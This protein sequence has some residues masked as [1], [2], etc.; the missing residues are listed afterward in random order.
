MN[1]LHESELHK[2]VHNAPVAVTA[3]VRILAVAQDTKVEGFFSRFTKIFDSVY[4][5]HNRLDLPDCSVTLQP[6]DRP[7][8][9]VG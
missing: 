9:L 5:D 6:S 3:S 7:N 1:P 2:R 4:L 8:I